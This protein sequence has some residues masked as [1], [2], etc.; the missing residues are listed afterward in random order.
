MRRLTILPRLRLKAQLSWPEL[1]DIQ[2]KA[3][4]L[5]TLRP[6]WKAPQRC[7]LES[8]IN[9]WMTC[10]TNWVWNCPKKK[11]GRKKVERKRCNRRRVGRKV[12][13]VAEGRL[14]DARTDKHAWLSVCLGSQRGAK[15]VATSTASLGPFICNPDKGK[16]GR[17]RERRRN[18]ANIHSWSSSRR[19]RPNLS[20][21]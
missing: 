12:N 7:W 1:H 4:S 8:Q 3:V 17:E 20:Q 6:F 9:G 5:P 16:K 10:T 21:V 13:R 18:L 14:M 2:V 11:G 15:P 19:I